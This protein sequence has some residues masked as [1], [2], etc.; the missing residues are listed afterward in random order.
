MPWVR[1]A[2]GPLWVCEKSA[3]GMP[4]P[5]YESAPGPLLGQPW[6]LAGSAMSPPLGP[7]WVRH[8]PA[9]GPLGII[10]WDGS[11]MGMPWVFYGNAVGVAWVCRGCSMGYAM[12]AP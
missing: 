4:W 8:G 12:N 6:G 1:R 5:S 3:M 9:T 7:P 10:V 2:V 11:A